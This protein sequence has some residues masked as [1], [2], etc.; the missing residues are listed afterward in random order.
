[1]D[2]KAFLNLESI[3]FSQLYWLGSINFAWTSLARVRSSIRKAV[4]TSFPSDPFSPCGPASP[5]SPYGPRG[6]STPSPPSDPGGPGF[7]GSGIS[8]LVYPP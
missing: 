3:L 1:M 2:G 6:P 5:R 8:V 4:L 7:G